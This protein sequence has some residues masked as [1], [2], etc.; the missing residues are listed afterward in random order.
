MSNKMLDPH[1]WNLENLFYTSKI[2]TVPVYQRPYFWDKEHVVVLLEDLLNDLPE[3]KSEGYYTGNLI[4]YDRNENINGLIS[5][6]EIIDGQQRITTLNNYILIVTFSYILPCTKNGIA[7]TDMTVG[8][9]K[10]ALRKIENRE[11][12]KEYW[13]VTLNSI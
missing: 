10:Q 1:M 7:D 2:Y 6:Y 11:Y 8:K 5:K 9:I 4:I 13:V 3:S 12:K